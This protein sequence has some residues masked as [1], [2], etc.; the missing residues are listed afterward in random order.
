MWQVDP[1]LVFLKWAYR[2]GALDADQLLEFNRRSA[3]EREGES[4]LG[5]LV[6]WD[7]LS[8]EKVAELL[9]PEIV[10]RAVD[11]GTLDAALVPYLE[12]LDPPAEAS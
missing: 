6:E 4:L 12:A 2:A 11:E 10:R 3:A 7:Y 5:L 9:A 1:E 8:R